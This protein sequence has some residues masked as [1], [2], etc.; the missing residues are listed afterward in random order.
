MSFSEEILSAYFDGEATPEEV[1]LVERMLQECPELQARL[2]DYDAIRS[3]IQGISIDKS[4]SNLAEVVRNQIA[5]FPRNATTGAAETVATKT[6]SRPLWT[7]GISTL[8]AAAVL[9]GSGLFLLNRQADMHPNDIAEAEMEIS[10]AALPGELAATARSL[11][12][13]NF[14]MSVASDHR[15]PEPA[16]AAVDSEL[17]PVIVSIP[18]ETIRQRLSSLGDEPRSGD[19]FS[20]LTDHEKT[21]ILVDFTVVDVNQ[22]VNRLQVLL[23]NRA[24]KPIQLSADQQNLSFESSEKLVA[25]YLDL[26]IPEMETVLSQVPALEAVLFVSAETSLGEQLSQQQ[27]KSSERAKRESAIPAQPGSATDGIK[28]NS[29]SLDKATAEELPIVES[30]RNLT[31]NEE[32]QFQF[33][34]NAVDSVVAKS[35]APYLS[36]AASKLSPPGLQTREQAPSMPAGPDLSFENASPPSPALPERA[37]TPT[38]PSGLG[39]E[40][41]RAMELK[42]IDPDEVVVGQNEPKPDNPEVDR[43]KSRLRAVLIL[44]QEAGR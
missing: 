11:N 34:F 35:S 8:A 6:Q 15:E 33:N 43:K 13:E 20:I 9:I 10:P 7:V 31:R 41:V 18:A 32:Q 25:V 16:S 40:Q 21:P 37:D 36:L 39:G 28:M 24:V 44:R 2:A 30:S 5:Q 22:A 27:V 1:A 12:E 4:S 3:S 29:Q 23:K 26:D 38:V 17:R 19:E 14:A 42:R